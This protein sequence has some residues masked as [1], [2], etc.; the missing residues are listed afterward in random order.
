MTEF[1]IFIN[2]L[3]NTYLKKYEGIA[4]FMQGNFSF[5]KRNGNIYIRLI[6]NTKIKDIKTDL[7]MILLPRE[8]NG[9]ECFIPSY[10]T[11]NQKINNV[12]FRLG[13]DGVD[14][15]TYLE[16]DKQSICFHRFYSDVYLQCVTKCLNSEDVE[17]NN[18]LTYDMLLSKP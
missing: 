9:K 8:H 15:G 7:S 4:L 11:V 1:D 5:E 17:L 10:I 13:K 2:F 18:L 12:D 3:N 14:S 16:I 6:Y